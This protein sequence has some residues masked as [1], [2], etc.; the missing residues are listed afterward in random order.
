MIVLMTLAVAAALVGECREKPISFRYASWNIG[1]YAYGRGKDTKV[2][3]SNA[4]HRTAS[5]T[6]SSG[7]SGCPTSSGTTAMT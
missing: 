2:A 3:E 1:H 4:I 6:S 5:T 7:A